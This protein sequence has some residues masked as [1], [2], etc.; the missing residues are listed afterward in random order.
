MATKQQVGAQF[1][2]VVEHA[3]SEATEAHN[4]IRESMQLYKN[5]GYDE[6]KWI[7]G[8][9]LP[10]K[11]SIDPKIRRSINRL[12]PAYTE[13]TPRIEIQPD[14]TDYLELDQE[15]I[16]ELSHWNEMMENLD[17]EEERMETMVAH[18]LVSGTTVAKVHYD[19]E[20]GIVQTFPVDPLNFA[21][22]PATT[23][24]NFRNSQFLAHRS[25]VSYNY[26]KNKYPSFR[27]GRTVSKWWKAKQI[28]WG[29][30]DGVT[31]DEL[32]MRP[33]F[34][35]ELGAQ[36][37]DETNVAV[38]TLVDGELAS[39]IQNPYLYPDFPFGGWGNYLDIEAGEGKSKGFWGTSNAENMKDQQKLLDEALASYLTMARNAKTGRYMGKHGS[40]DDETFYNTNGA[41]LELP[42][43]VRIEDIK[44]LAT[45]EPPNSLANLIQIFQKMVDDDAVS[46]NPTFVGEAPFGGASGRL[47]TI[48]QT[49]SFNQITN[50]IRRFNAFRVRMLR[51]RLNFIQQF[52]RNMRGALKW[53]LGLD[54]PSSL[55]N[56]ARHIGF[57]LRRT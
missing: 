20:S 23:T 31:I 17:N 53:R 52:A 26:A 46:L 25:Y 51:I 2:E 49:A 40:F 36:T 7:L 42:E 24:T 4:R 16:E 50:N 41:F 28:D 57:N 32:W 56:E 13:Q 5:S 30:K 54:L 45:A 14:R 44:E 8:L 22:D 12:I 18:N 55:S 47:A 6:G 27:S 1:K 15:P 48:L 38:A 3:F 19:S 37:T 43:G 39:L 11:K 29:W 21:P 33:K 35:K 34:A 10:T 9:T